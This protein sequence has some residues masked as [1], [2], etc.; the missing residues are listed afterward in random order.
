[1][2]TSYASALGQMDNFVGQFLE[3]GTAVK[4]DERL[5]KALIDLIQQDE[6]IDAEEE[7]YILEIERK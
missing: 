5:V 6:S 3:T 2:Q 1:M 7:F 4:K